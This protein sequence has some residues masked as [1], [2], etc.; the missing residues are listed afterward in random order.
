MKMMDKFTDSLTQ[1]VEYIVDKNRQ[2][3][4]MNRLKAIIHKE[5]ETLDNAF[6]ALGQKYL[7]ELEGTPSKDIDVA[8]LCETIK[9]SKLRLRK[10]RARYEYIA[11]YGVPRAGVKIDGCSSKSGSSKV[12]N[13]EDQDITIAYA[14]PTAD[15]ST[16]K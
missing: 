2:I 13:E 8:Q 7:S 4:Q 1:S 15:S 11:R 3:A 5:T 14:D 9:T 12:D 6:I 10:A 16:D